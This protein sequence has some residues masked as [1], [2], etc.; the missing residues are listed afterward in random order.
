MIPILQVYAS[1][2]VR[3]LD[4]IGNLFLDRIL[5]H[6]HIIE[7]YLKGSQTGHL[8]RR[9]IDRA[10]IRIPGAHLDTTDSD[11]SSLFIFNNY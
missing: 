1:Q 5:Y 8:Y 7:L 6:Q 3:F 9:E 10:L 4:L 2:S 11:E